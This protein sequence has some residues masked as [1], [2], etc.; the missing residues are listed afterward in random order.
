MNPR[1]HI[2]VH[3]IVANRLWD[4][5]PPQM[6]QTAQRLT[7]AGYERH[8]VLHMLANVVSSELYDALTGNNSYDIQDTREAL[9]A[10]PAS[11]E[12]LR[13]APNRA[14]RRAQARA[15]RR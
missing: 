7:R 2:A 13:T 9:K 5:N 11:W 1:M 8:E 6:W 12:P 4:D 15:P 10:L 3:E 14:V